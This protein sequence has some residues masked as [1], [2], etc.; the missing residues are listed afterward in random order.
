MKI[1]VNE[2]STPQKEIEYPWLGVDQYGQVVLFTKDGVG[3][4]IC[5][6]VYKLGKYLVTWDMEAFKEFKGTITLEN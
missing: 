5:P 4:V 3:T 6:N 2:K 1:T